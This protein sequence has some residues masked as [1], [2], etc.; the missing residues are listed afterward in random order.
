MEWQRHHQ[1]RVEKSRKKLK[2][3]VDRIR[4]EIPKPSVEQNK[5]FEEATKRHNK[6]INKQVDKSRK[7]VNQD[8]CAVTVLS[9]GGA[10]AAAV[11]T[12]R[13]WA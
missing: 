11:A 5:R 8:G 7:K 3:D 1:N 12:W 10:V 4:R 9:A 2:Q 13:G 6:V